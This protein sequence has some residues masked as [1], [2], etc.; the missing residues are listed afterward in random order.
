MAGMT[1]DCL[2]QEHPEEHSDVHSEEHSE[3]R[4]NVHLDVMS[5]RIMVDAQM[6]TNQHSPLVITFGGAVD[7]STKKEKSTA[8]SMTVAE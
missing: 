3:E 1:S 5:I 8:Q 4:H 2:T 7:W 6:T